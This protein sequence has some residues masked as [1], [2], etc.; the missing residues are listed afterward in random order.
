MA[1]GGLSMKVY[2]VLRRLD[3]LR[4][5]A[6]SDGEKL[7]LLQTVEG[8]VYTD[9]FLQAADFSGSPAPLL[10]ETELSVPAPFHDLYLHYLMAMVAFYSGDTAGYTESMLLYNRCWEDFAAH[11]RANHKPV[12][13]NLHGMRV[14]RR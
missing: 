12:Q 1:K 4:P 9:I 8:R 7:E 2:E 10:E 14:R 11:Y 13:K 6:F 5:N 3:S